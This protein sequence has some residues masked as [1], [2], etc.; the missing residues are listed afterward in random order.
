MKIDL[1]QKYP[2]IL[3]YVKD[4]DCCF[5]EAIQKLSKG[6]IQGWL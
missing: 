3:Q 6:K 1:K 4:H 2:G 5:S